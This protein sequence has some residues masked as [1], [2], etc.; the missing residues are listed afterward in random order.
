[1]NTRLLTPG[2]RVKVRAVASE[3]HGHQTVSATFVCNERDWVLVHLDGGTVIVAY[4][5]KDVTKVE[6]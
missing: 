5:S 1:M 3:I 2:D 4:P 6:P